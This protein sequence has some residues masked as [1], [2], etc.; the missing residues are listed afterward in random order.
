MKSQAQG[1]SF[2]KKLLFLFGTAVEVNVWLDQF[3]HY[4]LCLLLTEYWLRE[5]I[6][7]LDVGLHTQ[8]VGTFLAIKVQVK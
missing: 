8:R 7:A 4:Q 3:S 2:Q 5:S 1:N 6:N